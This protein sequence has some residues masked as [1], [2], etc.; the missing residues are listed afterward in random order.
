MLRALRLELE[1]RLDVGAE[2]EL[3]WSDLV[4]TRGHDGILLRPAVADEL[5]AELRAML[6]A[7][8]DRPMLARKIIGDAHMTAPPS[9]VLEEELAWAAAA[10]P[11]PAARCE[12]LMREPLRAFADG[13]TS[14]AS[15]VAQSLPRLPAVAR[16]AAATWYLEQA[17]R[18]HL[19]A[20]AD[21][22]SAAPA[23]IDTEA[24]SAL[25]GDVS[26]AKLGV[27]RVGD[28]LH[29]GD[30]GID[31]VAIDVLASNPRVVEVIASSVTRGRRRHQ[32]ATGDLATVDVGWENVEVRSSSG[33]TYEFGIAEEREAVRSI[34]V[35]VDPEHVGI[36]IPGNR[37]LTLGTDPST[38]QFSIHQRNPDETSTAEAVVRAD[39]QPV[40]AGRRWHGI[41]PD[42]SM[43]YGLVRIP[44]FDDIPSSPMAL[45]LRRRP[46]TPDPL[47]SPVIVGGEVAGIVTSVVPG[48]DWGGDGDLAYA[49]WPALWELVHGTPPVEQAEPNA[50]PTV[51][52]DLAGL[53]DL[54][55]A[56]SLGIH[57]RFR[58][59][60]AFELYDDVLTPEQ[61]E[62]IRVD[63]ESVVRESL[64]PLLG[65]W[66]PTMVFAVLETR[67]ER[68][69]AG[70]TV[71]MTL[72][73]DRAIAEE[74]L[75][76]ASGKYDIDD[77]R[78]RALSQWPRL[79]EPVRE[80][81]DTYGF[82]AAHEDRSAQRLSD[83]LKLMASLVQSIGTDAATEGSAASFVLEG[84][85]NR[86]WPQWR[87]F[88]DGQVELRTPGL[89]PQ[90][91]LVGF[92]ESDLD[93]LA[94]LLRNL[95]DRYPDTTVPLGYD[96]K[97]ST[98]R[99]VDLAQFGVQATSAAR[100]DDP[101]K[102]ALTAT[103]A[104]YESLLR[105]AAVSLVAVL[106]SMR[107][108]G[109]PRPA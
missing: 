16:S 13:R 65:T 86:V 69:A 33:G 50:S 75:G 101:D 11:D 14:V 66:D 2:S 29:L 32:V 81:A 54:L 64:S 17:S 100:R 4:G 60:G 12:E 25:L 85:A 88:R 8:D 15:W 68:W 59:A 21:L 10:D 97:D 73:V 77:L 48:A 45:Q 83:Y 5:R 105:A 103:F 74:V 35:G 52:M 106:E 82:F 78:R 31:G 98:I 95:A 51:S 34:T 56:V 1:H 76:D 87:R 42:G 91:D 28:R 102:V 18:P 99:Q 22:G 39:R 3:W 53:I 24:L 7:G 96:V 19:R 93:H 61:L 44:V 94:R 63:A 79:I 92:I 6:A 36:R 72:T 62:R 107:N 47:G 80:L 84:A 37:M 71:E 70:G 46:G 89:S 43:V 26:T 90:H 58:S 67:G 9:I 104:S 55:Q 38:D 30:V 109:P 108:D 40:E 41:A 49:E 23:D 20:G 57:T 27:M